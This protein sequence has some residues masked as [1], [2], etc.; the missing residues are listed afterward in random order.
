MTLLQ[1]LIWNLSRTKVL[2]QKE[3][4]INES[5]GSRLRKQLSLTVG[6]LPRWKQNIGADSCAAYLTYLNDAGAWDFAAVTELAKR[7]EH[8]HPPSCSVAADRWPTSQRLRK[9]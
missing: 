6:H 8:R 7:R 5:V 9:L 1:K 2:I 4:C 3:L